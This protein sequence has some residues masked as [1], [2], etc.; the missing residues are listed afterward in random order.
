MLGFVAMLI[1]AAVLAVGPPGKYRVIVSLDSPSE[2]ET[3]LAEIAQ[4]ALAKLKPENPGREETFGANWVGEP[5]NVITR[6]GWCLFIRRVTRIKGGWRAMVQVS[7][8]AT[9]NGSYV[10]IRN[11]HYELYESRRGVIS[12]VDQAVS[13]DWSPNQGL[14]GGIY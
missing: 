4:R 13:T 1:L 12:L 9:L 11:V 14:I 3:D 10:S 6:T 8:L 7:L 5:K 2:E